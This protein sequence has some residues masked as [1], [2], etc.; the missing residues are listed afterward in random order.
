M[1]MGISYPTQFYTCYTVLGKLYPKRHHTAQRAHK[2]RDTNFHHKSTKK[3]E[4]TVTLCDSF[5]APRGDC[6]KQKA[7]ISDT[8]RPCSMVKQ[9]KKFVGL[10]ITKEQQQYPYPKFYCW[11]S[12]V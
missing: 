2:Q 10:L 12:T 9:Q 11:T 5:S 4:E 7:L 8:L 1:V 3:T 6:V